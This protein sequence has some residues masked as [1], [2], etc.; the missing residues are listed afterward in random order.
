MLHFQNFIHSKAACA[1]SKEGLKML[2]LTV[3]VEDYLMLGDDIRIVFLGRSGNHIRVMVDAPKDVNVVRG[4]AIE[5]RI[6]D[7]ELKA[8][9]PKYYRQEEHPEK[10]KKKKVVIITADG[11]TPQGAAVNS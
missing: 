4:S 7:P 8:K 10:Y 2:R 6:E 1:A 9:L 3:N 11:K 5:K